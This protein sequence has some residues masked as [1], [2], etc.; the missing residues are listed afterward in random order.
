MPP[1]P[2]TCFLPCGRRV[3]TTLRTPGAEAGRGASTHWSLYLLQP[4]QPACPALSSPPLPQ[5]RLILGL[6]AA[7]GLGAFALVPTQELQLAKPS[8]PLF[9]Y[10]VPLLRWGR[11]GRMWGS[12]AG[13]AAVKL[14]GMHACAFCPAP[15]SAWQRMAGCLPGIATCA[16]PTPAPRAGLP[17]ARRAQQLLTE[18]EQL[19][20]EGD[21]LALQSLLRR[22]LGEP[23]NLQQNLRDA[24]ACEWRRRAAL[25]PGGRVLGGAAVCRPPAARRA[26]HHV[27]V[28]MHL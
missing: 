5:R 19:V 12:G 21:L 14:S 7:A 3:Q 27:N 13:A 22:I 28:S 26:R 6:V 1:L 23:N 15:P 4:A 11:G 16:V 10:L 2:C 20:P 18:A 9:F 25:F 8:K 24:A 17:S